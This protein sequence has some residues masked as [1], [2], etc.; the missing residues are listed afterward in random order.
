MA[1]GV[2]NADVVIPEELARK[3]TEENVR[4]HVEDELNAALKRCS[5]RK[6]EINSLPDASRDW[7]GARIELD[8]P[9]KTTILREFRDYYDWYL[10]I[11]DIEEIC[12]ESINE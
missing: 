5:I 3:A 11:N 9:D 2:F 1:Y 4:R 6:V 10:G 8:G 12:L 7:P